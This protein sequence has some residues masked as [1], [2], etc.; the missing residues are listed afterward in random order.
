MSVLSVHTSMLAN[1]FLNTVL[2]QLVPTRETNILDLLM[3]SNSLAVSNIDV[4]QP[5][6]ISDHG[7]V[8][9]RTWFPGNDPCSANDMYLDFESANYTGLAEYFSSVN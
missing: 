9:W 6:S 1:V 4:Y 8:S 7:V 3:V 5:F 2:S